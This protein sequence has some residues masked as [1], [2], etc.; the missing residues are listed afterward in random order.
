M[1]QAETKPDGLMQQDSQGA[2]E[3]ELR[4]TVHHCDDSSFRSLALYMGLV[5]L[6]CQL[7]FVHAFFQSFDAASEQ[8]AVR[9]GAKVASSEQVEKAFGSRYSRPDIL[10]WSGA[11]SL[12]W[13]AAWFAPE[14]QVRYGSALVFFFV[15]GGFLA[16]MHRPAREGG[17][18]YTVISAA[19]TGMKLWLSW[20]AGAAILL[21]YILTSAGGMRALGVS[22][23]ITFENSWKDISDAFLSHWL[24]YVAWLAVAGFLPMAGGAMLGLVRTRFLTRPVPTIHNQNVTEDSS[25][26]PEMG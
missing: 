9:G 6:L 11:Q 18:H 5:V 3:T 10:Q 2:E 24:V 7:V 21:V 15:A 19:R 25:R 16:A 14:T 20:M 17:M 13:I 26:Q 22:A 12:V 1:S 4:Q 23:G 8:L